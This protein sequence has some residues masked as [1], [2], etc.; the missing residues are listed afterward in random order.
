MI[1]SP[2]RSNNEALAGVGLLNQPQ[3]VS[4]SSNSAVPENLGCPLAKATAINSKQPMNINWC[5]LDC[6]HIV[7]SPVNAGRSP[8]VSHQ[9][10]ET[11]DK[12]ITPDYSHGPYTQH[13]YEVNR[14]GHAT[15][16]RQ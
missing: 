10:H 4:D 6:L 11:E 3:R 5:F 8:E 1:H 12:L 9:R 7:Q 15:P 14:Q 13:E 16:Y 2:S